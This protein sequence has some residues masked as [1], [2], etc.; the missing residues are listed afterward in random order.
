MSVIGVLVG[1]EG[2]E[3]EL[4]R[5]TAAYILAQCQGMDGHEFIIITAAN[6]IAKKIRPDAVVNIHYG[7]LGDGGS[8]PGLLDLMRIPHT[9]SDGLASSICRNKVL[10]KYFGRA[11]GIDFPDH[12]IVDP[13]VSNCSRDQIISKIGLP[14]ILKPIDSASSIDV[15]LAR[16]TQELGSALESMRSYSSIIAEPFLKGREITVGVLE[17]DGETLALPVIGLNI[18]NQPYQ[19]FQAKYGEGEMEFVIPAELDDATSSKAQAIAVKLHKAVNCI[20]YSR[21]DMV[22]SPEGEMNVLEINAFPGIGPYSEFPKAAALL[23]IIYPELISCLMK[24]G[25]KM[26]DI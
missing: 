12:V 25:K 21:T 7:L 22:V 13:M 24:S 11:A 6:L 23:G 9:G 4:S 8:A 14:A 2:K 18:K 20:G 17:K 19:N 1:N 15:F 26:Y 16:D 10:T 3:A 5:K